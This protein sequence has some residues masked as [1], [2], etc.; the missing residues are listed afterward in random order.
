MTIGQLLDLKATDLANSTLQEM[1][2]K[3]LDSIFQ[4]AYRE[5]IESTLEKRRKQTMSNESEYWRS[6]DIPTES[7]A[8]SDSN[9]NI[10]NI[11]E[12]SSP[13]ISRSV[14]LEE[15]EI[16]EIKGNDKSSLDSNEKDMSRL[17][18]IEK[19]VQKSISME[20]K[21]YP[22]SKPKRPLDADAISRFTTHTSNPAKQSKVE[23]EKEQEM[24]LS[25]IKESSAETAKSQSAK[26]K[27]P[28]LLEIFKNKSSSSFES[29]EPNMTS[30][31]SVRSATPSPKSQSR[32]DDSFFNP[33]YLINSSG[34]K[35]FSITRPGGIMLSCF[36]RIVDR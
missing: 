19:N 23:Y 35:N 2:S 13:S 32:M 12:G 8:P 18:E 30:S 36:G 25:S 26:L 15:D 29:D 24:I 28:N 34:T 5:S 27:A 33:F 1:R 7:L 11:L 20:S 17:M 4:G 16:D 9:Q 3:Q 21:K 10:D 31:S 14:S 6:G 22:G